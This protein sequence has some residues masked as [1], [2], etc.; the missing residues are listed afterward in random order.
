MSTKT[1]FMRALV[2]LAILALVF[3]M[4]GSVYAQ[5]DAALPVGELWGAEGVAH[6]NGCFAVG[7]AGDPDDAAA[8]VDIRIL[9][10]GVEVVSGPTFS[11]P[12]GH[13]FFFNLWGLI[14]NY[15]DH[16][17]VA[18]AMD[19]GT[20]QWV[21][22]AG[23]PKWLNCVNYDIYV[24]NVKTGSVERLTT[25]EDTGEY[26][27]SWSPDGMKIVHDV[28]DLYSH[29]LYITDVRT[30]VSTPLGGADGGNNGVW[31]PNGKWIVFD[32]VPAGEP[33]LY[34]LPPAGGTPK[35]VVSD[36]VNGGWSPNSQRLV[37]ERG[38]GLWTAS[39]RGGDEKQL[40]EAGYSPAWSPNGMWIAYSF[41]GDLWKIRV[42]ENGSPSGGP[43][44]LTSSSFDESGPTWSQDSKFIAFVSDVTGE[45]D[46]WEI[47]AEGGTPV[48]LGGAVGYGDYDAKYSNN[49]QYIAYDGAILPSTP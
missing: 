44:Q 16:M 42:D 20:G 47:P 3:S 27:P 17:I 28:T 48:W 39:V 31:S 40:V 5:D 14:S 6:P 32:R 26:N 36:A 18:Q 49:G 24:L 9:A 37:F 45:H 34:L 4:T 10:D 33:N 23:T 21:D 2:G 13:V 1:N 46:V 11:V 43:I 8:E 19:Q 7:W 12:E 15:T 35:L 22:L 38:G 41:D 29:A 30:K 25:L